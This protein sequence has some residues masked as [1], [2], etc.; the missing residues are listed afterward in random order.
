[1]AKNN[2]V[3]QEAPA[4][5]QEA[6]ATEA[7]VEAGEGASVIEGGAR[8]RRAVMLKHFIPDADWINKNVVAGGKGT[9]KLVGR[10]F[11][12]A[13]GYENRENT[14]PDGS[15]SK[16]IFVKGIFETENYLD[17]TVARAG[18]VYFPLAYAE[19][20]KAAFDADATVKVIEVDTDIGLEATGK[21]IP[22]E[23]VVIAHVEGKEMSPLKRLKSSRGRPANAPRLTAPAEPA[24]LPAS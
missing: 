3:E 4:T 1:M 7:S 8:Q 6:S 12:M 2:T 10:I 23:W 19:Q 11:G 22:Y 17:G 21:T 16:S 14:L 15:I 24:M 5:E 9:Q 18:G 20:I 13:T